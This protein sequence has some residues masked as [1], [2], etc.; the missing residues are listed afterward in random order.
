MQQTTVDYDCIT[1]Y[2][3]IIII[4]KRQ[5]ASTCRTH[6]GNFSCHVNFCSDVGLL[7]YIP[8]PS[9]FLYFIRTFIKTPV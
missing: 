5:L 4:I 7:T 2:S 1:A 3:T 9:R 8:R 6:N